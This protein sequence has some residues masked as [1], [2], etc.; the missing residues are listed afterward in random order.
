MPRIRNNSI[1][2]RFTDFFKLKVTDSLDSEAG[3]LI[4]PVI[5]FPLPAN[6][7][8]VIDA[9]LNDSN[10]TIVVPAGK[11]WKILYGQIIL[12]TTASA[13]NRNMQIRFRD[14]N[15][16]EI[17]RIGTLNVQVASTTERYNLGQFG[18]IA[19]SATGIHSFPI[20][21]NM[22]LDGNF[23]IQI[24]DSQAIDAAADDLFINLIVDET[25]VTGE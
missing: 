2:K 24:L 4:V 8:E 3:R 18:D 7:F 14:S 23:E 16:N 20:P 19:E 11:R 22:I 10:K 5:N 12:I 21:I 13:G 9:A 17:Y 6:I 15:G 1:A 25:D